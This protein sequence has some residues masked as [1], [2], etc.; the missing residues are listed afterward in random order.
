VE[1]VAEE[2]TTLTPSLLYT[3]SSA[4]QAMNL[5][6]DYACHGAALRNVMRA[7]SKSSHGAPYAR[8]LTGGLMGAFKLVVITGPFA[9]LNWRSANPNISI[10]L[11]RSNF[12]MGDGI[13]P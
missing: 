10:A 13:C 12:R 2:A 3:A 7:D 4:V 5:T 11:Q 6:D 1:G 8:T 9:R